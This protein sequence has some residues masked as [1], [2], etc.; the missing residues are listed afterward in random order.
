MSLETIIRDSSSPVQV[1][2]G[3]VLDPNVL[4]GP[5]PDDY[6]EFVQELCCLAC[7][8][9]V[10]RFESHGGDLMHYT[11]DPMFDNIMPIETDHAPFLP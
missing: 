7:Q 4:D 6:V 11:G 10:A 3:T 5:D 8:T 9:P 2:D 1:L